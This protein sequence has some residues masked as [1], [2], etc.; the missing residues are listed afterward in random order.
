ML[1]MNKNKG[2]TLV[3]LLVV[4]AIIGILG[5]IAVNSYIGSALKAQR[6]EAY[7]NLNSLRLLEEQFFSESATYTAVLGS[8]TG[9]QPGAGAT[10]TYALAVDVALPAPPVAVP[11]DGVTVAQ[12]NCFIATATG[13]AGTRVAGDVFAVDCNNNRNF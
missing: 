13:N 5:T 8:L 12:P 2:F 7:A 6:S 4:M 3:E 10:Y 1:R 11:Y 9:F